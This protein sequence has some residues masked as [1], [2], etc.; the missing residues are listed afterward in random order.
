MMIFFFIFN[1]NEGH[2][3]DTHDQQVVEWLERQLDM[4]DRSTSQDSIKLLRKDAILKSLKDVQ[5]DMMEEIG[6]LQ[7]IKLIYK[8]CK[9][10][11]SYILT[12]LKEK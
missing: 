5:T 6:T 7:F 4:T 12:H 11:F 9:K 3:W 10:H 1:S 2:L 8:R